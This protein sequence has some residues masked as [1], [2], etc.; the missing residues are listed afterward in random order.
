M[1]ILMIGDVV[2]RSGRVVLEKQLF[3]LREREKLDFIIA[4]VENATGGSGLNIQN[5]NELKHCGIDCMTLGDHAFRR[6]E[7]FPVMETTN[8]ILRPGNYPRS[9]PGKGFTFYEIPGNSEHSPLRLAVICLVGRVFMSPVNCPFEVAD[10]ILAKIPEDVHVRMVDF[11]AEATSEMQLLGR[12]LDGKVSA[13]LGTHTH[14]ATADETILPGGTA[15]QCDVGMTGPFESII[16]RQIDCVLET[17]RTFRPNSFE[18]ATNDCRINGT[19]VEVDTLT[20]KAIA[21]HRIVVRENDD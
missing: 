10:E 2:G 15:F 9:A 4:N 19:I 8:D 1:R 3:R 20:G 5:Y 6:K 16:G 13:V 18:I 21:I 17:T 11:H 12:Y 7:I 14:V